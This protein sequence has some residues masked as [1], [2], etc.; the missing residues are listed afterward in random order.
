MRKPSAS[1]SAITAGV[2]HADDRV[3]RRQLRPLLDGDRRQQ[4]L[5]EALRRRHVG[6]REDEAV[7]RRQR[8]VALDL[9]LAPVGRQRVAARR[10]VVGAGDREDH[11]RA[12]AVG[13]LALRCRARRRRPPARGRRPGSASAGGGAPGR[14]RSRRPSGRGSC[15]P[16]RRSVR[17]AAPISIR[18]PQST[19]TRSASI[20][21]PNT[22]PPSPSSHVIVQPLRRRDAAGGERRGGDAARPRLAHEERQ[23]AVGRGRAARAGWRAGG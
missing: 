15:H 11:L 22:V 4:V 3:L 6:D 10:A 18:W 2:E 14:G 1:N 19:A 5:R 17:L 21:S 9:R 16:T 23:L 12:A 8:G 20:P 13:V 7:H